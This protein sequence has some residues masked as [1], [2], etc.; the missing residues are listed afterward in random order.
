M[1][2]LVL[3]A[4]AQTYTI[5]TAAGGGLPPTPM[6]A[7]S[8]AVRPLWTAT[9]S[10][11]SAYFTS[12]FGVFKVD[13]AGTLTR[14]AGSPGGAGSLGDGGSAT[15]ADLNDPEG[16]AVDSSGNL[17]IAEWGANRI[18]KVTPAGTITTVAGSGVAGYSG[19]GG[20]AVAA[21][22]KGPSGI[23][24]DSAG[25]LYIVDY[26]NNAVRKVTPGGTISTVA[27]S[28][29]SGYSGD[30]GPATSATLNSPNGIAVDSSNDIYIADSDNAVVRKVAHGGIISTYAGGGSAT[31]TG[32]PATGFSLDYPMCVAV[33]SSGN[34]YISDPDWYGVFKVMPS[35]TIT[36]FAGNGKPGFSGD[37]SP[38][39]SASLNW[40]EGVAT[41][42]RG[43][44]YIGDYNN[45][46][47]RVVNAA[48]TIS[49]IAGTGTGSF[50]NGG[51]ATSAAVNWPSGVALD[52]SGNLYVAE[53]AGAMVRKVTPGG[54][55]SIFAGTGTTGY[56]GDGGAATAAQLNDPASVA[57]DSGGDLYLADSVN[58]AIRKVT[59]AGSI[60]TVAG[61][62]KAGFSGDGGAATSA[63]LNQPASVAVDSAGNLY[64]ADSV[65]YRI[66][67]VTTDGNIST[68]A[69]NGTRAY[70]GDGGPA[71]SASIS[72]P[73]NIA[74]DAA[75]NVYIADY[76]NHRIRMV[77][78]GGTI[79]TV[80]GNG[81]AG[82]SGDGGPAT[83]AELNYPIGVVVDSN[84]NLF[85]A[86]SYNQRIRMVTPAGTIS[87][88]AGNGNIG[89]SGDGGAATSA[90]LNYPH[91]LA[92]DS[93]GKVYFADTDNGTVR[94]LTSNTPKPSIFA[95]GVVPVYST[96]NTVQP[97]EWVSI[98]GENLASATAVWNSDFPTS[99]GG[100][101]VTIDGKSAYLWYVSS[102]QINV[103]VPDDTKTGSVP[104]VV[105]TSGGSA[106][107]SV[108]LASVAPA[109]LLLDSKHVTGI[110]LRS[111]GSGAYGGG[112]Y[113][114]IGPTGS[115]LGYRTVAAKA[116]DI[117]ELYATGFGP[118]ISPVP[119]GKAFSGAAW[120]VDAVN[121]KIGSWNVT[122][123]F[124]GLSGAGLVQINLTIP[125]GQGT[126]DV[127]LV[128]TVGGVQTPSGVVISLQ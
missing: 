115:S 81:T 51:P 86:D 47:V 76:N 104:V 42:S 25:N 77:T 27:G 122:P 56:T 94:E 114:I 13:A 93:A 111:N 61:T 31:T 24:L 39:T 58:N 82:F 44:V 37:G 21:M 66:R 4:G 3:S 80:A 119:A 97:G 126:G 107:S 7:K 68:I 14:V 106:T 72:Y 48:G 6:A 110:I 88:V 35:G 1:L 64:I 85:I 22:L 127:P 55:I 30:N 100:A 29:K 45:Y 98:Y 87:T 49:T 69:G 43:N 125:G 9:D 67:K 108:N 19:D 46:R 99:L 28:G 60:S 92:V 54:T 20:P 53:S 89:Y 12:G 41:D 38:A 79:S 62:G 2:A 52:S 63:K 83:A 128:A 103:Q 71:T 102:G 33:D 117:V 16:I 101:S 105:T 84:G 34:L 5:N 120:A 26:G 36:I 32:G 8:A 75:G 109:F 15:S 112:T 11:G 123:S 17:Y 59:E 57:V 124:A 121:V 70:S 91:A 116:G 78:P 10:D 65:N 50:G 73:Y 23:A 96:V 74:V 18:R 118:T 95:G 40:A 90:A 113:D